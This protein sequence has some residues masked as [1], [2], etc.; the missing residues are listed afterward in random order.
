M[1]N[2]GS[3]TAADTDRNGNVGCSN[4]TNCYNCRNSSNC[5]DSSGL[6][7]CSNM[8]SCDV[9]DDPPSLNIISRSSTNIVHQDCTNCSNCDD[10]SVST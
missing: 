4:M 3:T 2:S 7:G 6:V 8:E 1:G 5:T 9:I 10:C